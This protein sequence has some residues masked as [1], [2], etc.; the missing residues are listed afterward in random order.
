[1]ASS[2]SRPWPR[3]PSAGRLMTS[4]HP[5]LWEEAASAELSPQQQLFFCT[6]GEMMIPWGCTFLGW[7]LCLLALSLAHT[8]TSSLGY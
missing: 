7:S 8:P 2:E 4:C 6:P 5:I 1:M 3:S